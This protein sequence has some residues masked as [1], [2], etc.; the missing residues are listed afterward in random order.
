MNNSPFKRY[1]HLH[2]SVVSSVGREVL[3]FGLIDIPLRVLGVS[4]LIARKIANNAG[5]IYTKEGKIQYYKYSL[6]ELL[7]ELSAKSD[8]CNSIQGEIKK[9][10]CKLNSL[11]SKLN[12]LNKLKSNCNNSN[13]PTKCGIQISNKILKLKSNIYD[14]REKI[15]KL[16]V[17]EIELDSKR[18]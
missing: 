15:N 2:E 17:N 5:K 1:I 14:Q 4:A 9:E 12:S 13:N 16:E 18:M 10:Y 7:N 6:S 3:L 11:N 8:N